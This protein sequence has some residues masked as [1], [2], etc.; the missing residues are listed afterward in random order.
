[1]SKKNANIRGSADGA[2]LI[3]LRSALKLGGHPFCPRME[4]RFPADL[5]KVNA[6][7]AAARDGRIGIRSREP[8]ETG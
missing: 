1:M 8:Q 3:V 6:P 5:E 4:R 7:V 2:M